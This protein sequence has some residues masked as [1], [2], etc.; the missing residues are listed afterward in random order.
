MRFCIYR[1]GGRS[2]LSGRGKAWRSSRPARFSG[3]RGQLFLSLAAGCLAASLTLFIAC[4][5]SQSE[6]LAAGIAP[7][8]L[9]FHVLAASD[10]P[11]DQRLKL[12][13]RDLLLAEIREGFSRLTPS[14]AHS[15]KANLKA[16][17]LLHREELELTA[18]AFLKELGSPDSVRIRLE[19]AYFPTRIYGGMTFPCGVYDAVRVLI[20]EGKGHNWWC[21]LYP[22]LCFTSDSIAVVPKSSETE[23]RCLL[24]ENAFEGICRGESLVFGESAGIPVNEKAAPERD[25]SDGDKSGA[26]F[27]GSDKNS[28][29][30]ALSGSDGNRKGA[31]LS[32]SN[33]DSSGAASGGSDKDSKGAPLDGSDKGKPTVPPDGKRQKKTEKTG[34]AHLR[35]TFRFLDFFR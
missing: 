7:K 13:V 18:E 17:I 4:A 30:A 5:R 20:G 3:R 27:G 34:E 1:W 19:S 22:S 10:S 21:V 31:P 28:S 35:L 14:P 9:R 8:V 25:G 12:A 24:D 16:Y 15:E 32:G 6:S 2:N 33:K 26:A 23:L 29:D 11:E